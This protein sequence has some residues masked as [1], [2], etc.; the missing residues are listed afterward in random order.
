MDEHRHMCRQCEKW[1]YLSDAR[2][3]K[4]HHNMLLEECPMYIIVRIVNATKLKIE[5]VVLDCPKFK[6]E[7]NNGV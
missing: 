6:E 3:M 5:T 4:K 1:K 2:E 7:A